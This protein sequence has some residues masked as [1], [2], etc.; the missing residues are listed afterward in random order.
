[1]G[2]NLKLFVLGWPNVYEDLGPN[3]ERKIGLY[4]LVSENNTQSTYK[5]KCAVELSNQKY[6]DI[7]VAF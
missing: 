1:M 7:S 5:I 2:T 4:T 6:T 3:V